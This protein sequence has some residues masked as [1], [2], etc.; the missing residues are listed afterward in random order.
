MSNKEEEVSQL[1]EMQEVYHQKG[2]IL[3]PI[4]IP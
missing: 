2:T 4:S 3:H 1:K